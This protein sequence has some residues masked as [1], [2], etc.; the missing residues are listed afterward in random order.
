MIPVLGIPHYNRPDL[1]V[2]CIES[3]DTEVAVLALVLNGPLD[4][5]P[6]AHV[7]EIGRHLQGGERYMTRA[8]GIIHR[9]ELCQHPNAGCAGAWNEI[10]KLFPN[11]GRNLFHYWLITN[12]DIAFT[13]GDLAKLHA[14]V[15]GNQGE[16]LYG[17]HGASFFAITENCVQRAGLF[18]E[19]IHPVYLEDCDYSYRLKLLGL[20]EV[21]VAGVAAIHGDATVS[22][23]CTI[24]ASP[25]IKVRNGQ[26]HG[27]NFAYYR[28][29]WGGENGREMYVFPFND[30]HCPVWAWRFDPVRRA[31][32]LWPH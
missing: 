12:N 20:R 29:K 5:F 19:N 30:P 3:I 9:L 2:R 1:L 31:Q 23:S 11:P 6:L 24:N 27:G 13:P 25:E 8:G 32:Q 4:Q 28:A 18:D 10:I 14:A 22:G 21:T 7:A 15:V 26:T 16:L 17:N